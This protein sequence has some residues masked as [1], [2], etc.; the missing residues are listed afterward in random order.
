MSDPEI[1]QGVFT[2]IM[3]A[4]SRIERRFQKIDSPDD[5]VSSDIGI[6]QLDGI[7]M[8]LIAIGELLKRLDNL[9][10]EPLSQTHPHVDWRNAKRTRDFLSHHYFSVDA[11]IIFD[12]CRNKLPDMKSAILERK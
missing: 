6:D 4:I 8:M 2:Q 10:E 7:T 12:I 9:L 5:F 11:E 3:E 1:L